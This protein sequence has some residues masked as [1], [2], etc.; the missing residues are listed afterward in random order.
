MANVEKSELKVQGPGLF[1]LF[2]PIGS[3]ILFLLFDF[4]YGYYNRKKL[5]ADTETVM[6]LFLE[7]DG[8]ETYAHQKEYVFRQYE[9]LGYTE[10][11]DI[12]LLIYEDYVLLVTY[13]SYFSVLGVFTGNKERT[14]VSRYKGYYNE[15]KEAV[16]EKYEPTDEELEQLLDDEEAL[17]HEEPNEDILIN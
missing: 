9:K 3:I 13:N 12:S 14:A 7:R 6:T 16:V 1:L 17:E 8:L 4:C 11:D 5:D 15:Y 2:I 10:L